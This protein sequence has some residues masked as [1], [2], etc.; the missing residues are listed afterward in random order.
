MKTNIKNNLFILTLIITILSQKATA[1]M[2]TC[3]LNL[4]DEFNSSRTLMDSRTVE[5]NPKQIGEQIVLKGNIDTI[6]SAV[7]RQDLNEVY[8]LA[9][10]KEGKVEARETFSLLTKSMTLAVPF[11][12]YEIYCFK[13]NNN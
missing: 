1:E 10:S 7:I 12:S 3:H 6:Y 8:L 11:W 5:L 4:R 2:L 13:E 9:A